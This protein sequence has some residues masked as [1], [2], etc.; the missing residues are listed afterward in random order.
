MKFKIGTST[1]NPDNPEIYSR[2]ESNPDVEFDTDWFIYT[3][4]SILN[5]DEFVPNFE[6]IDATNE[7]TVVLFYLAENAQKLLDGND[8]NLTEEAKKALK[9]FVEN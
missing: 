3:N 1:P 9:A 7:D 6:G 8:P 5:T 2:S 4:P